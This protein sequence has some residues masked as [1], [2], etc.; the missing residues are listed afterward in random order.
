MPAS[1]ATSK[2][3]CCWN[4][5]GLM[6]T[7]TSGSAEREINNGHP[8]PISP[9]S[10]NGGDESAKHPHQIAY[11]LVRCRWLQVFLT[12]N[13]IKN[14]KPS[15]PTKTA[16]IQDQEFRLSRRVMNAKYA[17]PIVS[18]TLSTK[19]QKRFEPSASNTAW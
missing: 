2:R 10:L 18:G 1:E 8:C 3:A 4:R 6:R 16:R 9:N 11:M 7:R 17:A 12:N 13:E 15:V 14:C 5:N 19:H